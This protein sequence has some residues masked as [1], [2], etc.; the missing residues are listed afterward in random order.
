[1]SGSRDSRDGN[2]SIGSH[3]VGKYSDSRPL[4]SRERVKIADDTLNGS[5]SGN[6]LSPPP[7]RTATTLVQSLPATFNELTAEERQALRRRN[8]KLVKLLGDE[9]LELNRERNARGPPPPPRSAPGR[10]HKHNGAANGG[11]DAAYLC[12]LWNLEKAPKRPVRPNVK[13]NR[14]LSDGIIHAPAVAPAAAPSRP[15]HV[16]HQ[17]RPATSKSPEPMWLYDGDGHTGMDSVF[18]D[19][20]YRERTKQNGLTHRHT[21]SADERKQQQQ[22]QQ[23]QQAREAPSHSFS[24]LPDNVTPK[25][26]AMLGLDEP[27]RR[28]QTHFHQTASQPTTPLPGNI[29][30]KAAMMLG[31]AP[32][33]AGPGSA[34]RSSINGK[35]P[36]AGSS[37][38]SRTSHDAAIGNSSASTAGGTS[39]QSHNT[40]SS[41][42]SSLEMLLSRVADEVPQA[43]RPGSVNRRPSSDVNS[44]AS[45]L[46]SAD[47]HRGGAEAPYE[48][49][50]S[51]EDE[52]PSVRPE[53][54]EQEVMYTADEHDSSDGENLWE[55]GESTPDCISDVS[56]SSDFISSSMFSKSTVDVVTG[57]QHDHISNNKRDR[58]DRRRRADKMSRWLG[59]VVP[60]HIIAPDQSNDEPAYMAHEVPGS[61]GCLHGDKTSSS[62]SRHGRS[63]S[64]DSVGHATV[65]LGASRGSHQR[66]SKKTSAGGSG[67]GG[68]FGAHLKQLM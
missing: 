67:G 53:D 19:D 25:A 6:T 55:D 26:A 17:S 42:R 39:V 47:G 24:P 4:L 28:T 63:S 43:L 5:K 14:R 10:T 58:Q 57:D 48:D 51:S 2:S 15:R 18:E 29:T 23:Q 37:S 61:R 40:S 31:I 7:S 32:P 27:R 16:R 20:P 60:A 21:A 56:D 44:I 3:E 35:I 45:P 62:H 12:A 33:S 41:R 34:R 52:M 1:M 64:I 50:D 13:N 46:A 8:T 38:S 9:V 30:P 36:T 22:R 66:H 59:S 68:G 65:G 11:V 49:A 54:E